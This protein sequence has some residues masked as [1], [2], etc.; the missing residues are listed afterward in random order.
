MTTEEA[1]LKRLEQIEL[2]KLDSEVEDLI[3]E[4]EADRQNTGPILPSWVF[5]VGVI[6]LALFAST[7]SFAD[8]QPAPQEGAPQGGPYC[9]PIDA[10][11]GVCA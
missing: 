2:E 10:D 1:K 6:L 7:C 8:E 9:H 5:I 3:Q 4:I 11:M